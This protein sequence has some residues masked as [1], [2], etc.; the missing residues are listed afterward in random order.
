MEDNIAVVGAGV[1]GEAIAKS[2]L[3]RKHD[4]KVTATRREVEKLEELRNLGA[5]TTRDNKK[6][7]RDSDIIFVCVKPTDVK[8]VLKEISEE[9]EDKLVVSTAAT[10]PLDFY[11]SI[12]PKA[13][14]VRTMPNIAVL[15]QESF[16]AYCCD[17]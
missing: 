2:L 6:A 17:G 16:T 8:K 1:I 7:A 11:K 5:I 13:R 10:I 3:T 14:F 12:I 9:T 4:G 15:V